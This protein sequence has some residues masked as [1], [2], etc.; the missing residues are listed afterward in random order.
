MKSVNSIIKSLKKLHVPTSP[1]LDERIFREISRAIAQA[2]N[3]KSASLQPGVW[4][5]IKFA[6]AA[7]IIIAVYL[8]FNYDRS[9]ET[10][11]PKIVE[12]SVSKSPAELTTLASLNAAFSRGGMEAVEKQLT[13]ADKKI[14]QRPRE[15]ITVEKLLCELGQCG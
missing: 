11:T 9:M 15:R 10:E 12:I 6:V 1:E 5:I 2:E 7:V 4:R 13:E 3:R 14:N 8:S